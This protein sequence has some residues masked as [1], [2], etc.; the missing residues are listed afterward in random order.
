VW[1]AAG[2]P[3]DKQKVDELVS[4]LTALDAAGIRSDSTAFGPIRTITVWTV[5][6]AEEIQIGKEDGGHVVARRRGE[7]VILELAAESWQEIEALLE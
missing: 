6:L 4:K 3:I 7:D 2:A 5:E 1:R